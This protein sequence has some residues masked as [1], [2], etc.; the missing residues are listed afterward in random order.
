MSGPS[1]REAV[2]SFAQRRIWLL[3]RIN[4]GTP[5]YTIS[6]GRRLRG[7]L[8]VPALRHAL[9]EVSNRHDALRTSF[10][11]GPQDVL[12]RVGPRRPVPCP[13]LDLAGQ[14]GRRRQERAA[15]AVR[16]ARD[17]ILDP[18]TG[19]VFR[20]R[21]LRLSGED[22]I[23]LVTL[24]HIVFDAWS[25]AI[26]WRELS[27]CYRAFRQGTAAGLAP[28]PLQYADFA[29][30]QRQEVTGARMAGQLAYW[31]RQLRDL[32]DT[33]VPGRWGRPVD[34]SWRG[35]RLDDPVAPATVR[36]VADLSRAARVT[37]FMAY[38]TVFQ[39]LLRR[40]TGADDLA[41][42]SPVAGRTSSDLEDLI[43][44]FI[45]TLVLR[46][47][48]SGNPRFLDLLAQ[49]RDITL[50]AFSHQDVSFEH[51]VDEL[52]PARTRGNP[53]TQVMFGMQNAPPAPAGLADLDTERV[54]FGT[55]A[56]K[57]D[58]RLMVAGSSPERTTLSWVYRT[59]LYDPD[60]VAR[61]SGHFQ[62]LLEAV[63]AAPRGR[64]DEFPMLPDADRTGAISLGRGPSPSA[65]GGTLPDRFSRQ[66]HATP[67]ALA[68]VAG[69]AT[70]TY[71]ELDR[72]AGRLADR[73]VRAG[74]SRGD[75]VGV[76]I[77]R[78]TAMAVA[79][80]GTLRAGAAYV[81]L[82]P[83]LPAHRAAS[84][85]ADA[86]PVALL[87]GPGEPVPPDTG[88]R[89]VLPVD[90]AE[91]LAAG[92]ARPPPAPSRP[93]PG[94][95][96][97]VAYLLYTSGST[98]QPKGVAVSH[99]RVLNYLAGIDQLAGLGPGRYA[100]LQPLAVDSSVTMLYGAWFRGGTLYLVSREV[101]VD[102]R[103]LA[104]LIRTERIDCLKI[105]PSHLEALQRVADPAELMPARWLMIGG[106]S[107]PEDW[108]QRLA[109]LR[110]G[111][112]VYNHY[113][114]TETTVGVLAHRVAATG[115]PAAARTTPLGRPLAG[116]R[117]YLLD[118]TGQPVPPLVA[119]ELHIGGLP[120]AYGYHRRPAQTARQF[121]PDPFSDEPGARMYRT[122][123]RARQLPDGT[124]E[125][126][127]RDDDQVKIRG[128]RVEPGEVAAVLREH[129]DVAEAAVRSPVV[130]GAA[131][132]VGYVTLRDGRFETGPDDISAF[133]RQRLPE[134][135]VPATLVVLEA[136][137]LTS[138]GKLDVRALPP[139]RPDSRPGGTGAPATRTERRVAAVW[140]Q[141]LGITG[142]GRNDD[143][144]RLGGH[145]LLATRLAGEL[146]RE[147]GVAVPVAVLFSHSG[148][149]AQA[150][151][152]ERAG[153]TPATLDAGSCLVRLGGPAGAPPMLWVHPISGSASCYT[154]LARHLPEHPLIAIQS[155][156]LATG[157][158]PP[159]SVAGLTE[160]Y[161]AAV[162]AAGV[163][164][165]YRLG[166]W[167]MGGLVAY[168]M[169]QRLAAGG[170]PV[171]RVVLVDT[172]VPRAG[173]GTP[174][175]AELTA[176][177]VRDVA[178]T[179]GW[180][181]DPPTAAEL[182][183]LAPS[184]RLATVERW[185]AASG[186]M[187]HGLPAEDLRRRFVVF[188]AH[189][190]AQLS[191]RPP[192]SRVPVALVRPMN[193]SRR[194]EPWRALA[195]DLLT[196]KELPGDHYSLLREPGV[197]ELARWLRGCLHRRA[198][199]ESSPAAGRTAHR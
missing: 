113:G 79:V 164:G 163:T 199:D 37:P 26:F 4:P 145:S 50:D 32:P 147:L 48:L 10:Q 115:G 35:G 18:A 102:A 34:A 86:E 153:Q 175:D 81:P 49:A 137:P 185:L 2:A 190:L 165:P 112:Q 104:G 171:E 70:L 192:A 57:L 94:S 166:G 76:F 93:V 149:A 139:P 158:P 196:V 3:E 198:A 184:Q 89:V 61:M 95:G 123:D 9:T 63:T 12:Q 78:S 56:T 120:V 71:R 65:A 105:A 121:V 38:L 27:D 45:N 53:F 114:P 46:A 188:R 28:L 75:R 55:A 22:H 157:L 181:G 103:A 178:A 19:D 14:P 109:K 127:G 132:L 179:L 106:E 174:S 44:L 172:K 7:P 193:H 173:A 197:A 135:M 180:R 74:V 136:L 116:A 142:V 88:V 23:L 97:D 162:Q 169:A 84:I 140:Q 146:Q 33:E 161:L 134:H 41:V 186:L 13:V 189:Y 108:A 118:P 77:D 85:V 168:E 90:P 40:Y 170:R 30:R 194:A 160:R 107:S 96:A 51:V 52:R 150:A 155:P 20:V 126:L 144:F 133:L 122:G 138:H 183:E 111:C 187:P 98:G 39:I 176:A 69:G 60:D 191:Y 8:D 36:R 1:G 47:D 167:S 42:L 59:E 67:D 83:A 16:E 195:G 117:V 110:G 129:P 128:N 152:L 5:A 66:A 31:R 82:D 17:A 154:D 131:T 143:F 43:G 124:V 159:E 156:G 29:V 80:L 177:Y 151:Y 6:L 58:L 99:A 73:L 72:A 11:L 54:D 62:A 119:G 15:Q 101:A 182:A 125:F 141:L 24:H 130:D 64:I 91:L 68:V 21:L 92:G 100:M 87:V 148:L 25:S